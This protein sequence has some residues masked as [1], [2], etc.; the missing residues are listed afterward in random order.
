MSLI[1]PTTGMKFTGGNEEERSWVTSQFPENTER[2]SDLFLLDS[3][4]K[5]VLQQTTGG[6]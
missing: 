1:P 6:A 2:K 4:L 3:T 5:T